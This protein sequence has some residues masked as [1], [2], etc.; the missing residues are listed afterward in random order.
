MNMH[1][2]D[3]ISELET[4]GSGNKTM[5]MM[6]YKGCYVQNLQSMHGSSMNE[7]TYM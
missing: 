2:K 5:L 3:K 7:T 1:L 6:A 4:D